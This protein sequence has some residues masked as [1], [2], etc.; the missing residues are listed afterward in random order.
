M[1]ELAGQE[2]VPER[3]EIGP[4]AQQPPKA[5]DP[6]AEKQVYYALGQFWDHDVHGSRRSVPVESSH[7]DEHA[8]DQTHPPRGDHPPDQGLD[9]G[10]LGFLGDG[11]EETQRE[12]GPLLDHLGVESFREVLHAEVRRD[13]IVQHAEADSGDDAGNQGKDGL[14]VHRAEADDGNDATEQA[15][16]GLGKNPVCVHWPH[17]RMFKKAIL[18]SWG[19]KVN[20]KSATDA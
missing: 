12:R 17:C 8:E 10:I 19:V 3:E 18:P 9:D 5:D 15:K 11:L 2:P 20:W 16:D 14:G 7:K 13:K 4:G 6:H 1:H